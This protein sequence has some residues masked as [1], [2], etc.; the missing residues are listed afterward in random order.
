MSNPKEYYNQSGYT[1]MDSSSGNDI[2]KPDDVASDIPPPY[3]EG[4]DNTGNGYGSMNQSVNEQN[5]GLLNSILSNNNPPKLG[6]IPSLGMN[7]RGIGDWTHPLIAPQHVTDIPE[8][9]P[10]ISEWTRAAESH[11]RCNYCCK[12]FKTVLAILFIWLVL[13]NY[14]DTLGSILPLPDDNSRD[15]GCHGLST[16][17]WTDL[18]PQIDF[19]KNVQISIYGQVSSGQIIVKPL[20]NAGDGFLL[21]DLQYTPNDQLHNE[22]SYEIQENDR[23]F[24]HLIVRVPEKRIDET[25]INMNIEIRLPVSTSM[26]SIMSNNMNVEVYPLKKEIEHIYVNTSNG[27]LHVSRWTGQEITLI[28]H[29]GEVNIGQLFSRDKIRIQ[30]SNAPIHLL[31]SVESKSFIE[32]INDNGMVETSSIRSNGTV[33][34]TSSNGAVRINSIMADTIDIQTSNEKIDVKHAEVRGEVTMLTSNGPIDASVLS[35]NDKRVILGTSNG[36]VRLHM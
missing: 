9:A 33:A 36:N 10:V 11:P 27:H 12:L 23:Y 34:V 26:V 22:M 25:C 4:S 3:E 13:M 1:P 32:I 35:N 7:D 18:P 30:S 31:N 21:T 24:T 15:S 8:N 16:V 17:A 14:G 20:E 2:Y 6:N 19:Q 29:N 5:I 28:N